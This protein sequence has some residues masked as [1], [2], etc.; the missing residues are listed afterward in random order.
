M[1][2][3]AISRLVVIFCH[4]PERPLKTL[5][6]AASKLARTRQAVKPASDPATEGQSDEKRCQRDLWCFA[7]APVIRG[8]RSCSHLPAR[9]GPCNARTWDMR[10]IAGCGRGKLSPLRLRNLE[11][12]PSPP[13]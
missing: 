11:Q 12:C 6:T 1:P 7:L 2:V 10:T 5:D 9:L 4:S 3:L 13:N 8:T